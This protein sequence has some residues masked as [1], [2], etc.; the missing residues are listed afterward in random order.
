MHFTRPMGRP[1]QSKSRAHCESEKTGPLVLE[2]ALS[3][4][5]SLSKPVLS[6]HGL[7]GGRT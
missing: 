4:S 2:V 7:G 1:D 3:C 5:V 6:Y